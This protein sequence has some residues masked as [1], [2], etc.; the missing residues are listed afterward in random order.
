MFFCNFKI[1]IFLLVYINGSIVVLL[2]FGEQP[3]RDREGR[4]IRTRIAN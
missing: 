3:Y 2:G 1:A 4:V